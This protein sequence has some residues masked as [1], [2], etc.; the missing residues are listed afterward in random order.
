MLP[1]KIG[2][3]FITIHNILCHYKKISTFST[4]FSSGRRLSLF[5]SYGIMSVTSEIC[6]EMPHDD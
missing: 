6:E 2:E 1:V 5:E 3:I 4:K